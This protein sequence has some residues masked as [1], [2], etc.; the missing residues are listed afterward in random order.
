MRYNI[1]IQPVVDLDFKNREVFFVTTSISPSFHLFFLSSD[2]FFLEGNFVKFS[3]VLS[4]KRISL[5]MKW[6][7]SEKCWNF[8]GIF[9][10][11]IHS[12]N[13][14]YILS[15][16][17]WENVAS[18]KNSDFKPRKSL[19]SWKIM[20]KENFCE[21]YPAGD[22]CWIENVGEYCK[23]NTKGKENIRHSLKSNPILFNNA[24]FSRNLWS[25]NNSLYCEVNS[26]L[27][28]YLRGVLLLYFLFIHSFIHWFT[29]EK[30]EIVFIAIFYC[31][32]SFM[33]DLKW[34]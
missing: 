2:F 27:S 16:A 19:N 18:R 17:W 4:W 20:K 1:L 33:V 26:F 23:N 13:V 10:R 9:H 34:I 28:D 3:D 11:P 30:R 12:Y 29:D 24:N 22:E 31:S 21:K 32:H 14:V 8:S 5:H 15:M 25:K 7:L 6:K